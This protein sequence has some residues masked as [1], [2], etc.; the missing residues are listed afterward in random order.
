MIALVSRPGLAAWPAADG[1]SGARRWWQDGGVRGEDVERAVAEMVRVLGPQDRLDWTVPAGTL[2]WSC[3]ATAAHVAHDLLAYAGQVAGRPDTAY[4]PFDLKIRTD[5]EAA[6]VLAT[7]VACGR[8]LS[9]AVAAADPD[10]RAWHFGPC[11]RTGFAAMGVAETLLHTVDIT[12]GLGLDWWPPEDLCAAVLA[13]LFP[14]APEGD[15]VDVLLWSTGRG[16]LDGHP[17]LTSW[18]WQAALP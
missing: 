6:E 17:R 7:V 10:D 13:R 15:A 9:R 2:E 12:R 1:R 16:E 11:D 5:A 18:V 3:W 14:R 4:L 8:L